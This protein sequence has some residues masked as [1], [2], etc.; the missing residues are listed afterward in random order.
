[1]P[2]PAHQEADAMTQAKPAIYDILR[3]IPSLS[4]AERRKLLGNLSRYSDVAED[5]HDILLLQ[6]RRGERSRPYQEFAKE[7]AAEGR[8]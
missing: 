3:A 8:S 4:K 5:M 6:E 2:L 7:L 1:M